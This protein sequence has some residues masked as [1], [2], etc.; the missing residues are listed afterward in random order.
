MLKRAYK[1]L[2]NP[3]E[4]RKKINALDDFIFSI[5]DND[6]LNLEK[7][8]EAIRHIPL[9]HTPASQGIEYGIT[10]WVKDEGS[11]INKDAQSP[12]EAGSLFGTAVATLSNSFKPQ[13]DTSIATVRTFE[14]TKDDKEH[15]YPRE[16]RYGT[17]GQRDQGV[18]RPSPLYERFL[19]VKEKRATDKEKISHIYFNVLGYD[20]DDFVGKKERDLTLA[21]H[22]LEENHKNVAVITLP[23][24]KGLMDKNDYQKINDSHDSQEVFEEFLNIVGQ[25]RSAKNKVKDFYISF[26]VR[27]FLFQD[28][29]G[30]YT[31]AVEKAKLRELLNNGFKALGLDQK[32]TLTSAERQAVWFHFIKSELTNYIIGRIKPESINFSCKDAI[33]RGGV[34]SAYYNLMRSFETPKPLSREEFERTLHAAPT[35][36][37]GRGMNFHLKVIWNAVDSYVN[38]NYEKLRNDK[39]KAWLI[40]WRDINCPHA[41]VENLLDQRIQQTKKEL[42]DAKLNTLGNAKVPIGL[43]ILEEIERQKNLGVSGKRALLGAVAL[44]PAIALNRASETQ[45]KTYL[46]VADELSI[47]Y[48]VLNVIAGLMK[49]LGGAALLIITAGQVKGLFQSG[50]ATLRAGLNPESREQIIGNMKEMKDGLN[51]LKQEVPVATEK[52]DDRLVSKPS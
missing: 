7:T 15:I 36:V 16:Y 4:I 8:F 34:S 10:E 14:Y 38:A 28:D 40:E 1:R 45:V 41:R 51:Q 26:S 31:P 9:E 50:L 18:P 17:Q 21:L 46:K 22:G 13:H 25:D 6:N 11:K 47:K 52:E 3:D 5:Y 12:A 27:K 19:K 48:P 29:S 30:N 39:E 44:T 42:E 33:D 37:K 49:T 35:M 43:Q 32:K 24:D 2:L 20:R 23:A